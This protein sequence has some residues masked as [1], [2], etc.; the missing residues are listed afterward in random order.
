MAEAAVAAETIPA[1]VVGQVDATPEP[2]EPVVDKSKEQEAGEAKGEAKAEEPKVEA[3]IVYEF[4]APEG[5]E[6][7]P[8]AISS[9]TEFAKAEKLP[10]ELAQKIVDYS[11]KHQARMEEAQS[12]RLL[13][14]VIAEEKAAL[15]VLKK[16]PKLGGANYEQT[17]KLAAEGFSKFASKEEIEFINTTR[18]GNRPQMISLFR[19]IALAMREDGVSKRPTAPPDST[20]GEAE[21]HRTLYPTMTETK[22]S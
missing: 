9:F 20:G 4:K 8:D 16:D 6:L 21:L 11:L 5:A 13:D 10:A 15:E 19:K 3:E 14:T 22:E 18:L 17:L 7:D 2:T 12:K 1:P